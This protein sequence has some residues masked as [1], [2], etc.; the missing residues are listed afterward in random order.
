M[1]MEA[2][3]KLSI[4][5]RMRAVLSVKNPEKQICGTGN[6][7]HILVRVSIPNEDVLNF[8]NIEVDQDNHVIFSGAV[9]KPPT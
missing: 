8:S 5:N 1:N 6:Y 3:Y 7:P 2:I 9:Y 4:N